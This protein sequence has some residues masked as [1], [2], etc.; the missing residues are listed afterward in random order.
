MQDQLG[1][2]FK[3]MG[4]R[5]EAVQRGLGEMH[6]LAN[7]V[8]DLKKVL[9]NVKTKGVLGELQLGRLLDEMLTPAQYGKNVKTKE[10]SRDLVEF[11][12]KIPSKV[13]K[14]DF[15]WL[16]IDSKFP[17]ED[18]DRLL[19]A[20]DAADGAE[21]ERCKKALAAKIKLFAKEIAVKYIDVPHTTDFGILFLPIEGLYAEVLRIPGLFE[22]VQRE[23]KITIT[24]PTT[25]SAFISSLQMGFRTL[26]IE[27]RT[28]EIWDL[29]G[30]VKTEFGK[31]GESIE[32]VQRKIEEAGKECDRVG[33]RTRA[34]QRQLKEV[35]LLPEGEKETDR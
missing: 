19:T 23:L 24:G 21:I 14:G 10:G 13:S 32:R 22:T 16:P 20:Y 3:L 15:I 12:V 25:L 27:K 28:Q 18:Y 5:L 7:G 11:A 2:S 34:I 30:A 9:S 1:Q 4:E 33:V 35:E 26:A 29:L 8:G 31:F 17:T 6:E